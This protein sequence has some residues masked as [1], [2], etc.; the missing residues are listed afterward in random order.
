MQ[1]QDSI[2]ALYRRIAYSNIK[3]WSL[4]MEAIRWSKINLEIKEKLKSAQ[5]GQ[6]N[7]IDKCQGSLSFT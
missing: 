7:Y 5:D 3:G 2:V 4:G 6:T 1:F